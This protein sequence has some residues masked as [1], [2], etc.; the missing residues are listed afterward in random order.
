MKAICML[1]SSSH[2]ITGF[3]DYVIIESHISECVDGHEAGY[4]RTD[5]DD[6]SLEILRGI[7]WNRREYATHLLI[8]STTTVIRPEKVTAM[9]MC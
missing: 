2:S 3:K 5:D 1:Y 9:D 7:Y 8:Y 6:F 4:P